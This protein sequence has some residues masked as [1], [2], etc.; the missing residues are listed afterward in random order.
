MVIAFI[1]LVVSVTSGAYAAVRVTTANIANRA[2]TQRTLAHNA[3]WH[4]N[5][6]RGVVRRANIGHGGVG[7][8]QL[9]TNSVW[10]RNLGRHVVR[11]NNINDGAVTQAKLGKGVVERENLSHALQSEIP[12]SPGAPGAQGPTGPQGPEGA[13]GPDG[14]RGP[15]G[16]GL[17]NQVTRVSSLSSNTNVAAPEWAMAAGHGTSCGVTV[18]TGPPGTVS[19]TPEGALITIPGSTE[20]FRGF[21]GIEF[22]PPNGI[23]LEDM[24]GMSITEK[25]SGGDTIPAAIPFVSFYVHESAG[26]TV[27]TFNPTRQAGGTAALTRDRFQTWSLFGPNARWIAPHIFGQASQQ[28]LFSAVLGEWGKDDV[29]KIQIQVGCTKSASES[30][31]TI[32][33]AQLELGS[34]V[35]NFRFKG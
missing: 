23:K 29:T 24:T 27:I 11:E 34:Q 10:H 21:A 20:A 22:N 1:A 7:H 3:V 25:F 5:L 35:L 16:P 8:D 14:P 19:L 4:A 30:T 31:A 12:G 13:R 15:R 9:G 6:G 28:Q 18:P 17:P 2:V 33:S 26:T 32:S